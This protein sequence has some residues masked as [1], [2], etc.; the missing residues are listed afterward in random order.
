MNP[1]EPMKLVQQP[2]VDAVVKCT[3]A[4]F[5]DLASQSVNAFVIGDMSTRNSYRY[6]LVEGRWILFIFSNEDGAAYGSRFSHRSVRGSLYC[7]ELESLKEVA[8][9][10]EGILGRSIRLGSPQ[11]CLEGDYRLSVKIYLI[12]R[13]GA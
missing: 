4:Q 11:K 6:M 10:L 7:D 1:L 13:T 8:E 9:L 12:G 3:E 2:I 5:K